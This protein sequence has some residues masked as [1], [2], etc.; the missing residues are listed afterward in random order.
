MDSLPT[1]MEHQIE[2]YVLT[3]DFSGVVDY[4]EQECNR[5]AARGLCW[6]PCE[7]CVVECMILEASEVGRREG[8]SQ[9]RRSE[10]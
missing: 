4:L 3:S 6:S 5:R 7:Q 8:G 2:E 10:C 9:H 1:Y